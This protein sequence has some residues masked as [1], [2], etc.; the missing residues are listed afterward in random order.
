MSNVAKTPHYP[1]QPRGTSS[2]NSNKNTPFI[3]GGRTRDGEDWVGPD[4]LP[5]LYTPLERTRRNRS[6]R[7]AEAL[8]K[9]QVERSL[10]KADLQLWNGNLER[11]A[12]K[13]DSGRLDMR[14][15]LISVPQDPCTLQE[16]NEYAEAL[17]S[18][19]VERVRTLSKSMR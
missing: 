7:E 5:E 1:H 12:R 10:S 9:W 17:S 4:V 6:L 16:L 13:W 8:A 3:S 2:H 18:A 14:R 11:S 19:T 15:V